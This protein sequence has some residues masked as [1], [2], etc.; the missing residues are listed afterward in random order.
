M[1]KSLT[2]TSW[3]LL[4]SLPILS[5]SNSTQSLAA[6]SSPAR[7]QIES[8]D[9]NEYSPEQIKTIAERIT[10]RVRGSNSGASGTLVAKEGNSYLVLTNNHVLHRIQ[11]GEINIQTIDGKI[12]RGRI[13]DKSK[14]VNQKQF[15]QYDLAILEFTS[16]EN[17]CLPIDVANQQVKEGTAVLASGY[18]AQTGKFTFEQGI[19]KKIQREPTLAEGY[20]IGYDSKVE[21]GMS[22]GPIIDLQGLLLGING[23]SAFPIVSNYVYAD[24]TEPKEAQIEEIRRLSWGIPILPILAQIKGEYLTAYSLPLPDVITGVPQSPL[25]EWIRRIEEKVKQFTV[26]IDINRGGNGSGVI[27]AKEGNTYTVLTAAHV[28]EDNNNREYTIVTGDEKKHPI[29]RKSIKLEEGVDLAVVKFQSRENYPI[30]TLADYPTT[31]Y[32]YTYTAG[33]PQIGDKSPWRF[34]QGWIYFKEQ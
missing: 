4:L 21:Q 20:E 1:K 23:Q 17:Y 9:E 5:A 30:A 31:N 25:P 6:S 33:Y 11:P 10:V 26:R 7:C 16:G 2:I 18:S 19:V 13:L 3:L 14:L 27:I 24:G 15:A 12:H 32:Q 28:L 22:G 8:A 29:D 34:T